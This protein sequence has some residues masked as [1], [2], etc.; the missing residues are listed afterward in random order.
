MIYTDIL[1]F[2]VKVNFEH[3]YSKQNKYLRKNIF[4]EILASPDILF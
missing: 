3:F 2:N 1:M 4:L